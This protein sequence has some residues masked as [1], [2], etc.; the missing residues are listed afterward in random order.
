M[1]GADEAFNA[2]ELSRYSLNNAASPRRNLNL[3][4]GATSEAP[5]FFGFPHRVVLPATYSRPT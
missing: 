5:H 1:S 4:L 3:V 2:L